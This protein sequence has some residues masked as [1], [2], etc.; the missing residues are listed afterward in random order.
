[1]ARVEIPTIS[2]HRKPTDDHHNRPL[3][4]TWHCCFWTLWFGLQDACYISLASPRPFLMPASELLC[5]FL[6]DSLSWHYLVPSILILF[7]SLLHFALWS[8]L[9]AIAVVMSELRR[10]FI[11]ID[12]CFVE[13]FSMIMFGTGV[14][15]ITSGRKP[16]PSSAAS[17]GS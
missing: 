1:M 4:W 5:V 7:F 11:G 9:V 15:H 10:C 12:K 8:A 14:S 3:C 2:H 16:S 17:G 6:A 13:L